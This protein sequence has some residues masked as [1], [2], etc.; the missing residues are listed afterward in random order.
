MLKGISLTIGIILCLSVYG[1]SVSSLDE[2]YGFKKFKFGTSSTLYSNLVLE[3][4]S[5]PGNTSIKEFKYIGKD[6]KRL[7]DVEI[8]SVQLTFYKDRLCNITL[9]FGSLET[10][11]EFTEE[12][13]NVLLYCFENSYGKKWSRAD[14]ESGE[15]LNGVIWVGN[16]VKLEF[17]RI[18]SKKYKNDPLDVV[19]GYAAFYEETI[20]N[21]MIDSNL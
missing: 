2:K 12:Q 4:S 3:K 8:E 5:Y 10:H 19:F 17:I 15:I 11:T 13:Y 1:Q 21:K 7:F 16:K 9:S 6:L 18:K 14:N 20:Y